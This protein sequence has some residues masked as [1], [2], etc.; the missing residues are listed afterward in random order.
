MMN[1]E[2]NDEECDATKMIRELRLETKIFKV[3]RN[4]NWL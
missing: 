1:G 4:N 3:T 2:Q